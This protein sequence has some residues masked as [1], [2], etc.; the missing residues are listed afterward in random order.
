MPYNFTTL[1]K[2]QSQ[3]KE[4]LL[5]CGEFNFD[6]LSAGQITSNPGE[7]LTSANL[8]RV[9]HQCAESFDWVIIDSPPVL[10]AT[11]V[12]LMSHFCDGVLLVV[13]SGKTP[14]KLLK[15]SIKRIGHER[16]SGVLMN[17]VKIQ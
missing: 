5:H 6:F 11:D 10:A 4:S 17:R 14:A 3:L 1:L 12:I 15:D 8:E 13:Q 2:G 16:I 9:L 7:F